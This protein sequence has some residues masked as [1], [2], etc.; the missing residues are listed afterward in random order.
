MDALVE[1]EETISINNLTVDRWQPLK[2][3]P[4]HIY[5]W[6]VP[7]PSDIPAVGIVHDR[8]VIAVRIVVKPRNPALQAAD[9]E[10][11]FDLVRDTLDADLIQPSQ[12]VLRA[13]AHETKRTNT[14]A[15]NPMFNEITYLGL[16][17]TLQA[18]LR[19]RFA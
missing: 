10:N 11:Y 4:P 17:F 2:V 16:E 18:D 6:L 15:I 1:L 3:N 12:S 13:A 7:S 8:L 9:M 5:N 19:R 14:R